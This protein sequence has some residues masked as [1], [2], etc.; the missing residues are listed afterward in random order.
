MIVT[1]EHLHSIPS[2]K[3]VGY[4]NRD[5][6]VWFKAHGLDWGDFVRNGIHD[7]ALLGTDA[8]GIGL[9][10]W[11]RKCAADAEGQQGG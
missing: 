6:R 3:G 10:E 1:I 7:E 2:R 9:V 8:L 5:S 11:A 4:C